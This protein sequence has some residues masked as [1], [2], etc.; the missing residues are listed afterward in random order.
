M[1]NGFSILRSQSKKKYVEEPTG[2]TKF[3]TDKELDQRGVPI[4][5]IADRAV[6]P[7]WQSGADS[8]LLVVPARTRPARENQ[9]AFWHS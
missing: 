3:N 2:S 1:E 6:W 7:S 8:A 4:Q 9:L 5:D